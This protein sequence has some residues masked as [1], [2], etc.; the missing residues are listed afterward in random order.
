[1]KWWML[2]G[3]VFL[4]AVGTAS[5]FIVGSTPPL[6]ATQAQMDSLQ[7]DV[8]VARWTVFHLRNDYQRLQLQCA[9][10]R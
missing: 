6:Y 7:S 4:V 3:I 10:A 5:G 9:R 2:I 1:M 8:E